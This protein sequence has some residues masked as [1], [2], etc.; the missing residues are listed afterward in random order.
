MKDRDV[1]CLVVVDTNGTPL[2][3]VT[4]RDIITKVCIND[5]PTSAVICK[6]ILSTPIITIKSSSS[7]SIAAEM[8]IK[9]DV[10][11]LIVIDDEN[12][13]YRYNYSTRPYKKKR[14]YSR[15]RQGGY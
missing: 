4:E 3:I 7:T 5:G 1:T 8:M 6:E 15:R 12:K 10:R 9:N 14:I 2:C 11:H 13:P